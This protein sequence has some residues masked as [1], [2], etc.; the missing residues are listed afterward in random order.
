MLIWRAARISA[1]Q[2]AVNN[3]A[4]R[5]ARAL[6]GAPGPVTNE[7]FAAL[8]VNR[9]L[10]QADAHRAL[11]TCEFCATLVRPGELSSAAG[12]VPVRRP[13]GSAAAAQPGGNLFVAGE[14]RFI[15]IRGA[16]RRRMWSKTGIYELAE[17]PINL[18]TEGF[19][20]NRRN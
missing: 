14:Y 11:V 19:Q 13:R 18:R 6:P 2:N 12:I 9:L 3:R 1:E 17:R 4:E 8:H 10:G 20:R 16:H 15:C 5:R 7:L